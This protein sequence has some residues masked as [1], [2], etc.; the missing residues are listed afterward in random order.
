VGFAFGFGLSRIFLEFQH[1]FDEWHLALDGADL[2]IAASDRNL[3]LRVNDLLFHL[4]EEI[5][6][7]FSRNSL[8]V[9]E[10]QFPLREFLFVA[11]LSVWCRTRKK[12]RNEKGERDEE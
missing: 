11:R 2:T 3:D 9:Q 10:T 1:A 8:S 5:V 12:R 4:I 7:L 6:R